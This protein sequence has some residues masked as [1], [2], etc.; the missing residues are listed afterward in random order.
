MSTVKQE[1]P[2]QQQQ[3]ATQMATQMATQTEKDMIGVIKTAGFYTQMDVKNK[4]AADV[5]E[6]HGSS[7]AI[8]H[9]L[10][11]AGMDY[12]SMRMMYG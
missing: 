6:K 2:K 1:T 9:M 8:N 7:A 10:T 11:S 4:T 3:T 12:G 5:M